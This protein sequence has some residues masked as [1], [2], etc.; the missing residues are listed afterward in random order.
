MVAYTNE[1]YRKVLHI[2]LGVVPLAYV[3]FLGREEL[4]RILGAALIVVLVGEILRM[5]I[6]F[7]TRIYGKLFGMFVRKEENES[8]TAVSITLLGIILTLFLFEKTVAVY[9]LLVMT[10]GDSIAAL[11]GLRWGRTPL[12]D[13]SVQGTVAFLAVAL[14]LAFVT[15]GVPRMPAV[16][17]AVVAT[18]AELL[19]S[20]VND[21]LLVPV[22]TGVTL[23]LANLVI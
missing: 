23:A 15:P 17:S 6:P 5:R 14:I 4:L 8:F 9:A 3:G 2:L 10:L 22:G 1:M 11:V 12:F 7:F 20:P 19:P 21:N 13:K 18:L 16:V